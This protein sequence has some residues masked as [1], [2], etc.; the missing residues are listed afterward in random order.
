MGN[1]TASTGTFIA[2]TT[3]STA[4]LGEYNMA[5]VSDTI[6]YSFFKNISIDAAILSRALRN[7]PWL[8]QMSETSVYYTRGETKKYLLVFGQNASKTLDS[9]EDNRKNY[10][11]I[12]TSRINSF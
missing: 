12:G 9:S 3:L 11:R 4:F 10:N 8:C 2:S 7:T 6:L 5:I 1:F